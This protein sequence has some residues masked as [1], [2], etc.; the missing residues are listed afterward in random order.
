MYYIEFVIFVLF[1]LV[2]H[3]QLSSPA[4]QP[5]NQGNL[6]DKLATFSAASDFFFATL[7]ENFEGEGDGENLH[8][9]M[10]IFSKPSDEQEDF[11]K[12]Q[13][14]AKKFK[15]LNESLSS[16]YDEFFPFHV[17]IYVK[18]SKYTF[19][20]GSLG[21]NKIRDTIFSKVPRS[22]PCHIPRNP[23]LEGSFRISFWEQLINED[24][25][26]SIKNEMM[27]FLIG[28]GQYSALDFSIRAVRRFDVETMDELLETEYNRLLIS[29]VFWE[30][31][32]DCANYDL[33]TRKYFYED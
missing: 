3:S 33:N 26:S 27:P 9:L 7:N 13:I 31:L 14:N 32:A 15:V 8:A 16:V 4:D 11:F 10:K 22:I 19:V 2:S 12:L 18:K 30:Y 28:T 23:F 29:L 20:R 21:V 24:T 25:H 1:P 6:S 5:V 17:Y